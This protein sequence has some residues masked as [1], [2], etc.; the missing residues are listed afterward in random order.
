MIATDFQ[1]ESVLGEGLCRVCL[2]AGDVLA[3]LFV[4]LLEG[5]LRGNGTN[6]RDEFA[7]EQG[8]E[9]FGLHGTAAERGSRDRHGFAGR[10][11]AD[12]EIGLDVDA[13]AVS[14]D[15]GILAGAHDAHRL[16]V[17]VDGRV[18]VD[19]RQHERA[20]VDHDALAEQAGPDE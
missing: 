6:G 8:V 10:L 1:L 18:V 3:A 13:H 19:E 17:H 14:G 5:H 15:H 2:E 16:H 9:L 7:G 20:A 11:H 4:H 12:I